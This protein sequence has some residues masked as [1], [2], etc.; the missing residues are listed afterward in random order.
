MMQEFQKVFIATLAAR[1]HVL[2]VSVFLIFV[3][4]AKNAV[5]NLICALFV[6]LD[7]IYRVQHAEQIEK[8]TWLSHNHFI[9]I[10]TESTFVVF[11]H[12]HDQTTKSFSFFM[13]YLK[14]I[15]NLFK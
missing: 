1:G 3:K 12:S 14:E 5:S 4:H 8:E 2:Q 9:H 6:S 7:I 10:I 13:F 11:I 15:T